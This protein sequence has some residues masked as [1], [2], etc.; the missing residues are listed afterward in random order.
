MVDNT[1][2]AIHYLARSPLLQG[3][4]EENLQLLDPP[5][6]LIFLKE[7]ETLIRK[8][9]QNWDRDT[10]FGSQ[11]IPPRVIP[12]AGSGATAGT[13]SNRENGH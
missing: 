7:G 10:G 6:E 5:P 8:C 11:P 12:G 2:K 4:S 3:V 1:K 9:E 13:A